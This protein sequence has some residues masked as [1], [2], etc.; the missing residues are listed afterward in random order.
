[1]ELE[2]KARQYDKVAA[3]QKKRYSG[4]LRKKVG[5]GKLEKIFIKRLLGRGGPLGKKRNWGGRWKEK[6]FWGSKTPCL[7]LIV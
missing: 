4:G 7:A 5:K 3:S 1:V 6:R 2:Q